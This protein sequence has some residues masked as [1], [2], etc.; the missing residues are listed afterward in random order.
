MMTSGTIIIP[1]TNEC[2][3]DGERMNNGDSRVGLTRQAA[4][5]IS[6]TQYSNSQSGPCGK[7][8]KP[9]LS[10]PAEPCS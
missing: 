6:K 8:M 4:A 3:D 7:L 1:P 2:G 9:E 5:L 10:K